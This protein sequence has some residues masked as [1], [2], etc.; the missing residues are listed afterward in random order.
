MYSSRKS[1]GYRMVFASIRGSIAFFFSASSSS[2]LSSEQ[3]A[4]GKISAGRT[5]FLANCLLTFLHRTQALCEFVLRNMLRWQ[6]WLTLWLR[7]WATF[8]EFIAYIAGV[9]GDWGGGVKGERKWKEKWE[10]REKG[11]GADGSP[12]SSRFH[13]PLPPRLRL[14]VAYH[15]RWNVPI[16]PSYWRLH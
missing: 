6:F 10:T 11:G 7:T 14:A 8:R 4:L 1:T 5:I 16:K 13:P 3:R 15:S 9:N 12:F 2:S